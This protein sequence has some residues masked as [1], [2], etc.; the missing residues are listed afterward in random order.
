MAVAVAA[1]PDMPAPTIR[2]SV[3][4]VSLMSLA[5]ISGA[6]PSQS[7]DV[8]TLL[9][10]P[11]VLSSAFVL[12]FGAQPAKLAAPKAPTPARPARKLRREMPA[13]VMSLMSNP[14][15]GDAALAG[16]ACSARSHIA[17]PDALHAMAASARNHRPIGG[18]S[19]VRGGGQPKHPIGVTPNK[20]PDEDGAG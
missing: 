7:L 19:G 4:R 2:M 1:M 14:P 12:A 18:I 9:F 10:D 15:Y 5:A 6:S 3:S 8:S 20:I 11:V 17:E 13:L 16:G